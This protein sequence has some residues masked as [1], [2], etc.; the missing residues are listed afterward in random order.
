MGF[1]GR[2][3][4]FRLPW[5]S[6][7]AA[8]KFV[9]SLNLKNHQTWKKYCISGEKP[10]DIPAHP[11]RIY[12][13]H[14]WESLG[15]WIGTGRIADQLKQFKVFEGAR[16]FIRALGLRNQKDW[17]IYLKSGNKPG[18]IPSTPN[19]VY[20]DNGWI[21]WGN[22]FATGRIAGHLKQFKSFEEARD[23]VRSLTLNSQKEWV[24]FCK[25]GN[26]PGD[27]PS[28]PNQAYKN[29]GWVSWGDW[30]GTGYISNRKRKWCHFK[31]ARSFVHTLKLK[32]NTEWLAYCKNKNKRHDIPP[33][34]H[35]VYRE[36]GWLSLGDWLGTGRIADHFKQF[37]SFGEARDIVRSLTLNGQKEWRV[38][39][40]S[41]N[42]PEDIP[43]VPERVYKN[44]GWISW[45]D[46][47]G[48]SK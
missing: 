44:R 7:E 6:F 43:S 12:T 35:L 10:A 40:R 38:F 23:I 22:W 36:H 45:G 2:L 47:L 41:G 30:F 14:G 8:R 13:G 3:R 27:I 32:N 11:D 17:R 16:E 5:R 18:D 15:N 20:K 24:I 25:S 42:K 28:A 4:K 33:H 9:Q 48:A 21:S 34:P 31:E 29:N 46:W 26:K 19:Q 39:C 1:T 37:K